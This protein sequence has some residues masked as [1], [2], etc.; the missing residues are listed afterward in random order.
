MNYKE[1]S[2]ILQDEVYFDWNANCKHYLKVWAIAK[3]RNKQIID[4]K[5]W[6]NFEYWLLPKNNPYKKLGQCWNWLEFWKMEK[7][8]FENPILKLWKSNFCNQSR[9]CFLCAVRKSVKLMHKMKKKFKMLEDK[10]KD[11][12][13]YYITIPVKH[14]PIDS[15]EYLQEIC[16]KIRRELTKN[17]KLTIFKDSVWWFFTFE[18]TYTKNWFNPHINILLFTHKKFELITREKRN[19]YW[20]SVHYSPEIMELVQ[21]ITTRLWN[22]S[23]ITTCQ[24]VDINDEKNLIKTLFELTKYNLKVYNQRI[25]PEIQIEVAET[26]KNKRFFSTFGCFYW[27]KEN[28]DLN[29]K[30]EEDEKIIERIVFKRAKNEYILDWKVD[31]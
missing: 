4:A 3:K 11:T 10:L 30:V 14:S 13:C 7:K 21:K 9:L 16:L 8:D 15:Y 29:A 19:K 25:S 26:S 20:N 24:P 31:F 17:W 23:Y 2:E 22:P 6:K 28:V 1:N 27:F 5:F 12:N 18:V